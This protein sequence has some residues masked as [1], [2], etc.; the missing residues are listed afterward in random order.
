MIILDFCIKKTR[1]IKFTCCYN[2]TQSK[3]CVRILILTIATTRYFLPDILYHISLFEIFFCLLCRT[4]NPCTF[5]TSTT[6][7]CKHTWCHFSL[8]QNIS[9]TGKTKKKIC[10]LSLQW[11]RTIRYLNLESK[12]FDFK[13]SYLVVSVG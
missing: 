12:L 5:Y 3:I 11:K 7:S 4:G 8:T 10:T 13:I 9:N 1:A 2:H 6:S